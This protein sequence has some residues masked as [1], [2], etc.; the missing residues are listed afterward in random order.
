MSPG[1]LLREVRRRHGL[2]QADVARRAS[3]TARQIG[4]IERGEIS[5]SVRTLAR[6]LRAM[7]EELRLGTESAALG[8]DP[9]IAQARLDLRELTPAQRVAQA[10]G[11]SRTGTA[12]AA[13]AAVGRRDGIGGER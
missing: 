8:E 12:I 9:V 1:C 11:L 7:G 2:T 13:A 4:R 10:A 6:L 5:P 3:T